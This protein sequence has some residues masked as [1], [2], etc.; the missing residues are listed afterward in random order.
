MDVDLYD[1]SALDFVIE[2]QKQFDADITLDDPF[3]TVSFFDI[4]GQE[5]TLRVI[6]EPPETTH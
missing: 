6:Q 4:M 5:R 3:I 2:I 1:V